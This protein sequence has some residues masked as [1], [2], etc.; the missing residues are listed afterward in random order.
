ML[1]DFAYRLAFPFPV[2]LTE[3]PSAVCSQ[4]HPLGF[5]KTAQGGKPFCCFD[6]I[7]CLDG[8]VANKM[9]RHFLNFF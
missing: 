9:G 4:R 3:T 1:L 5:R 7:P 2:S 6:C 8:E